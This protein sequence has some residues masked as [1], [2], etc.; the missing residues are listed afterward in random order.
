MRSHVEGLAISATH[1]VFCAVVVRAAPLSRLPLHGYPFAVLLL[2]ADHGIARFEASPSR[3]PQ[4]G[5]RE[6]PSYARLSA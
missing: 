2:V 1:P 5:S 6:I 4:I 3:D